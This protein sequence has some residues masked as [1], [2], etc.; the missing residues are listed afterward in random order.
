MY[1]NKTPW[2]LFAWNLDTVYLPQYFDIIMLHNTTSFPQQEPIVPFR[3]NSY[4][5]LGQWRYA[6]ALPY[7]DWRYVIQ[8]YVYEMINYLVI[9]Y[10]FVIENMCEDKETHATVLTHWGRVTHICVGNLTVIGSDNGF[11][12]GRRQAIIWANDGIL[13][14]QP[15]WKTSV[16]FKSKF[17][18]IHSRKCLW[19]CRLRNGVRF[20]SASMC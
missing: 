2:K 11:S 16:K 20:V 10:L 14:I 18:H 9:G 5:K 19:R 6:I 8:K 4:Q 15:L 3:S 17:Y 7:L 12:R 13:L 1:C